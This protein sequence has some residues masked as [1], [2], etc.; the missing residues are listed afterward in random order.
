MI[1]SLIHQPPQYPEAS[2]FLSPSTV[3]P[4][5]RAGRAGYGT[6]TH[7]EVSEGVFS[8][9]DSSWESPGKSI[10]NFV[11]YGGGESQDPVDNPE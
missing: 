8:H 4:P 2:G 10:V 9:R 11:T 6:K 5:Y 1:T 7:P 3:V